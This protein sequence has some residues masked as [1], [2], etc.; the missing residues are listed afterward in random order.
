[1]PLKNNKTYC[2]Q[3]NSRRH[4]N[5]KWKPRS[6]EDQDTFLG[7]ARFWSW[8]EFP[9]PTWSSF[10]YGAV[11]PQNG[12][13]LPDDTRSL[14]FANPFYPPGLDVLVATGRADRVPKR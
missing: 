7:S 3:G 12:I 10:L 5:N 9:L 1:M 13:C 2:I 8:G 4:I 14:M 6:I 11:L